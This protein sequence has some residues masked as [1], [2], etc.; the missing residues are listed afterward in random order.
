VRGFFSAAVG[1]VLCPAE[2][3]A[4]K[5]KKQDVAKR[6]FPQRLKLAPWIHDALER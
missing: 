1:T 5:S 4:E 3:A 6:V 2:D